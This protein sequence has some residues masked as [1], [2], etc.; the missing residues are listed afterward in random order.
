MFWENIFTVIST[1]TAL[2]VAAG[3]LWAARAAHRSASSAHDAARYAEKVDLR[4][5]LRDLITTCH[6]VIAESAQI[7]SLA[8]ELKTE[9]RLLATFSG[10]SGSKREKVHILRVESK[11]KDIVAL[12]QEAQQQIKQR[13]AMLSASEQEVTEAL[14]KFDGYLV[15]VLQIKG[16]LEREIASVAGNNRVYREGRIKNLNQRLHQ[17]DRL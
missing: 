6:R 8:E 10:Q 11:Q 3:G 5:I 1:I 4:G 16:S 14:I 7:D 15:Q 9:Y 2:T 13:T 17:S 12:Q